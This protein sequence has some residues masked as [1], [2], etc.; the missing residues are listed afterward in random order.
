MN[1]LWTVPVAVLFVAGTVAAQ[2]PGAAPASQP[3][4]PAAAPQSTSLSEGLKRA[5]AGVKLNVTEA[6]QKMPEENY[7][8][9]PTPEVRSFGEVIGHV[10]NG[11]YNYCSRASGEP[12]PKEN[13]EKKTTKAELVKA[14]AES[15]AACDAVINSATDDSLLQKVKVGQNETARGVFVSGV[16]A[17][18][19]EHYGN[20]VSY[21]RLKGLV[22][23]STERVQKAAPMAPAKKSSQQ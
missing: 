16:I 20:I 14:L 17:H 2:T 1:R 9:K 23:P 13:F 18:A 10:V 8:F 19:N 11:N 6:A 5:W 15:F 4:A 7:S 12:A 3:A 22:P 21:M